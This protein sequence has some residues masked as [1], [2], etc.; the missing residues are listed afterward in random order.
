MTTFRTMARIAAHAVF[1]RAPGRAYFAHDIE[2]TGMAAA[3]FN[4]ILS[5]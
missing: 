3:L 2:A 4:G 5:G 1:A